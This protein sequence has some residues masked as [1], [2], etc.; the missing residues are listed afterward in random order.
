M[1]NSFRVLLIGLLPEE[2]T[3]SSLPCKQQVFNDGSLYS[4][5]NASD[6]SLKWEWMH[7]EEQGS[8]MLLEP[9]GPTL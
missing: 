8:T 1:V 4:H 2:V 6:T 9:S 5:L 3:V 7:S